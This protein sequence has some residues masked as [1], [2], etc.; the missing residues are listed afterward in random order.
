MTKVTLDNVTNLIDT[1][2]AQGT[3]NKNSAAIVAAVEN[4]LS[5]DGTAPNQMAAS[6]DMNSNRILNLPAPLAS[7]EP[8][9][10]IDLN[11]AAFGITPV[12]SF[13]NLSVPGTAA[14]TGNT[15]IG[16]TLTTT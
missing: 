11:N 16:G 13:T 7:G 5:R 6:L 8:A 2:T 4:T 3:I 14:I 10:V 1:T 9:R 12:I 15:T